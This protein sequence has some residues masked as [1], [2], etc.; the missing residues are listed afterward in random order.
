LLTVQ[1]AYNTTPIETTKVLPFFVNY[2]YKA[3][4]RRGP[5]VAVPRAEVKA[6]QL[7]TLYTI[8]RKELKFIKNRMK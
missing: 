2:S 1:L 4:L 5:E 6:D 3:D 8:L 7:Y